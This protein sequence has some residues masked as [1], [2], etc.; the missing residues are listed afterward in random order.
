MVHMTK[1]EISQAD[2]EVGQ[3]IRH[4]R[5][6]ILGVSQQEFADQIRDVSRGAVNNWEHGQG[7]KRE[8]MQ[9]VARTFAISFEW[10]ATGRGAPRD[11]E[12]P[13]K[14]PPEVR[15]A[16]DQIPGGPLTEDEAK[17]FLAIVDLIAKSRRP[18]NGD[19]QDNG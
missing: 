8:N 5:R 1:K 2:I 9:R 4:L 10:L 17:S 18:Q 14:L 15:E 11:A 6:D 19:S 16:I 7:I 12:Q 3:R 13:D